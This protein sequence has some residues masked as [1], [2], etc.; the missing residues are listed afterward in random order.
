MSPIMTAE[1]TNSR[2]ADLR[3]Q[4]ERDRMLQAARRARRGNS[5]RGTPA[6]PSHPAGRLVRR[7]L[8]ALGTRSPRPATV[9]R[10]VPDS[11]AGP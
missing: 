2:M 7:A 1:L 5:G 11:P 10:Q 8:A 4:A 6:A 9:T 3:R